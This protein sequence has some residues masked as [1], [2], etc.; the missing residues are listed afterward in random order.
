MAGVEPAIPVGTER[1]PGASPV[2]SARPRPPDG[3]MRGASPGRV[4][5]G[6]RIGSGRISRSRFPGLAM[7]FTAIQGEA[8]VRRPRNPTG[9][10]AHTKRRADPANR[11]V[12]P[13]GRNTPPDGNGRSGASERAARR[14]EGG[15]RCRK[16]GISTLPN[17]PNFAMHLLI[18]KNVA[19][20]QRFSD[21]AVETRARRAKRTQRPL[22]DEFCETNPN[23][24]NAQERSRSG[25]F[26]DRSEPECRSTRKER[27]SP[28]A[29]GS[30]VEPIA[31]DTPGV[32]S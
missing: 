26:P 14:A 12:K 8:T 29:L 31:I 7:I 9:A 15:I 32:P 5:R 18:L 16:P 28:C 4:P 19:P 20:I 21:E 25:S 2:A 6:R 3:G 13:L 24:R 11:T 23:P 10:S 22:G 1:P 30:Y 17:E 27:A